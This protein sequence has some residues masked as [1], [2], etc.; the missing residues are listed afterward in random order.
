MM[1]L[2]ALIIIFLYK[3]KSNNNTP[4]RVVLQGCLP[5]LLSHVAVKV[6]HSIYAWKNSWFRF[7]ALIV[8]EILS[9]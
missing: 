9:N 6:E 5:Q 7:I 3:Q 1:S 4:G 8:L 2:H